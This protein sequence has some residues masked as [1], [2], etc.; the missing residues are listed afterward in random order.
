[1]RPRSPEGCGAGALERAGEREGRW[2]LRRADRRTVLWVAIYFGL[3]A[4]LWSVALPL[5]PTALL[6]VAASLFSFYCSGITHNTVHVPIFAA[7]W[8][9]RGF[10]VALTLTYGWPV[11]TFVAGHNLSHHEHL[12]TGADVARTD[13]MRFRWNFLNFAFFFF[14]TVPE[15]L[16]S[17]ARFVRFMRG[18]RPD[19]FRLFVVEAA[20]LLAV[21]LVLLL[22]DGRKFLFYWCVPHFAAAWGIITINYLQHDG[23]D[24]EAELAHSRN[25]VGPVFNYLAFN[26]GF[27]TAHHDDPDVHWS[28]LPGL[29]AERVAPRI[30]PGLVERS[31]PRYVW[32]AYVW[33]GRRL[34]YDG[35]P[36]K[37]G[38]P[39]PR[40]DWIPVD[41]ARL[42]RVSLGVE[43]SS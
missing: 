33:P 7:P 35:R 43:R 22:L 32:R 31:L 37:V 29:H 13:K 11:S 9:N 34:R 30:H 8:A 23:C 17:E 38:Q 27:H 18:R 42:G 36:V 26:N 4:L 28:L 20:A 16:R 1:M 15:L 3:V 21:S 39:Q 40:E 10:Q 12:Q 25:F 41:D 24:A 5:G 14:A 19:W 2:L 6:V